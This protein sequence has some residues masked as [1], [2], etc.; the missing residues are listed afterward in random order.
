M[1][2][3]SFHNRLQ[4]FGCRLSKSEQKIAA[5]II[6]H[7]TETASLGSQELVKA[8]GTSNSTL[9]RF[10]QKLDYRNYIEFQ[11]LLAAEN[12]TRPVPDHI[13][14]KI[15]HYYS[16]VL[17]ASS[18]LVD[19]SDLDAFVSRIHQADKIL[20]FGVGSSGLTASEFN[21]RLVQMGF[22]SSMVTDSFLIRVQSSLFSPR[23]LVIAVS[24]SGETPEVVSACRIAKSVSAQ[25]CLL[26]QNRQTEL[27]QMADTVLY[28]GDIRQTKD[29]LF[30][31]S[32][33]PLMFLIDAVSY[34]L[35]EN[36]DCRENRERSLHALF[37][38]RSF[39]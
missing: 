31:N 24:N 1:S 21:M 32:Q 23:D 5:Y 7:P 14:Q 10:C 36:T 30:I 19:S 13:L 12:T 39:Y 37:H 15:A 2:N 34:R 25:I 28:A 6:E 3:L 16:N 11:T 8:I 4:V 29:K 26:T 18:E 22:T 38:G 9:T 20:V 33:M 35:L 27:A 17:S